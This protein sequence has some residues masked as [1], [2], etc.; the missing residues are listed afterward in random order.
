M[1][2]TRKR[3]HSD[4]AEDLAALQLDGDKDEILTPFWNQGVYV[5][6]IKGDTIDP[7]LV[8]TDPS[9]GAASSPF[10]LRTGTSLDARIAP[11]LPLAGSSHVLAQALANRHSEL[12]NHIH[13]TKFRI[14]RSFSGHLSCVNALASSRGQGRWLASAG[15]DCEIHIRDIFVH[16]DSNIQTVPLAILHGHRGN[17]F[18]LSWSA[19]NQYL[20]ST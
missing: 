19:Q 16:L 12:S 2:N 9:F 5:A 10:L 6:D 11:R 8:T 4:A 3:V 17:I 15:G 20:Y 1:V 14:R 18:S 7:E 13:R